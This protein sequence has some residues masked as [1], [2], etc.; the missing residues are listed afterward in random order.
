M[1][2]N[3]PTHTVQPKLDPGLDR[4]RYFSTIKFF[5]PQPY[6]IEKGFQDRLPKQIMEGP[7]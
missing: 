6:P 7:Y 2:L 5:N 3:R 4:P 1:N